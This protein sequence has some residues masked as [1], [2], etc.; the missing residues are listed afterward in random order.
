MA[1]TKITEQVNQTF[2]ALQD[3][4]TLATQKLLDSIKGLKG[5]NLVKSIEYEFRDDA[6]VLIAFDYYTYVSE[7][8]RPR[9]RKVP[10]E[11]LIRWIKEKRI[12]TRGKTVSQ[13]AFAIQQAIYKRG[14]KGKKYEDDVVELSAEMISE[15]T[16]EDLS[17]YI[18]DDLVD[19][20]EQV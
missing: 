6:F 12:S 11:S 7:G 2:E 17:W 8:R 1:Y 20:I 18:V 15:T 19:I 13:T 14:I 10:V 5:S 16:A 9:A 4:L 3:E